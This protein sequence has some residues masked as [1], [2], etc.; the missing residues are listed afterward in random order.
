MSV[1]K[2]SLWVRKYRCH[3][4]PP[5]EMFCTRLQCS[6]QI[7][8]ALNKFLS[9]LK[10]L[11]LIA[12]NEVLSEFGETSFWARKNMFS[13]VNIFLLLLSKMHYYKKMRKKKEKRFRRSIPYCGAGQRRFYVIVDSRVD[14]IAGLFFSWNLLSSC[15]IWHNSLL[16]LIIF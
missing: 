15:Q 5:F 12:L 8:I 4:R 2:N 3:F 6:M 10:E 7:K 16:N 13:R 14:W 9:R 1:L 11:L